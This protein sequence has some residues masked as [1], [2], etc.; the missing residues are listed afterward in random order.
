M[1]KETD[2]AS[3]SDQI[4]R[5]VDFSVGILDAT[6]E[7]VGSWASR[8]VGQGRSRRQSFSDQAGR[9]S[10]RGQSVRAQVQARLMGTVARFL[11]ESGILEEALRHR[12]SRQE[13][14]PGEGTTETPPS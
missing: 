8:M 12:Q 13:P 6:Q 14:P 10:E 7:R 5:T 1:N 9:L 3:W 11:A 2:G 4:L